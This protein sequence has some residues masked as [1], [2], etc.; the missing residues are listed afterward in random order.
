MAFSLVFTAYLSNAVVSG[1]SPFF[2]QAR[3]V[4]KPLVSLIGRLVA[5]SA[6]I[7]VDTHTQT[8]TV[9]LA[10]HARRGSHSPAVQVSDPT[11]DLPAMFG[12]HNMPSAHSFLFVK[13]DRTTCRR[14]MRTVYYQNGEQN[15]TYLMRQSWS[16]RQLACSSICTSNPSLFPSCTFEPRRLGR[17]TASVS[18]RSLQ[19]MPSNG[20]E[21]SRWLECEK[22]VTNPR[23]RTYTTYGRITYVYM[24][25]YSPV[26]LARSRSPITDVGKKNATCVLHSLMMRTRR[27]SMMMMRMLLSPL[28]CHQNFCLARSL[29][30]LWENTRAFSSN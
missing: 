23:M 25:V 28:L 8:D 4:L 20:A 14:Y 18:D 15:G 11:W 6:R 21:F 26:R 1:K 16:T 17:G 7:S 24:V 2:F 9:T 13:Q 30:A 19:R 10:A 12:L 29:V 27:M 22:R 3:I 5:C